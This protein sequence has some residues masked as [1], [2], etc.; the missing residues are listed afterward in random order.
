MFKNKLN[1]TTHGT[2]VTRKSKKLTLNFNLTRFSLILTFIRGYGISKVF[3][4]RNPLTEYGFRICVVNA[5]NE[6]SEYSDPVYIET[7][8]KYSKNSFFRIKSI[9][10]FHIVEEPL[11]G[12]ELH[13]AIATENV[14]ELKTILKSENG[15]KILEIPDKFGNPPL[16]VAVNSNNVE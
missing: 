16:I 8:S 14:S 2:T 5:L 9:R 10:I 4:G 7:I 6:R 11:T 12:L 1:R 15:D 3:S 13:R